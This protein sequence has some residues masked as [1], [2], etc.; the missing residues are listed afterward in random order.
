M[1]SSSCP[2]S[3]GMS[4]SSDTPACTSRTM[5]ALLPYGPI[6]PTLTIRTPPASWTVRSATPPAARRGGAP[7]LGAHR[8]FPRSLA[9]LVLLALGHG[10][11]I[12][13]RRVVGGER[14]PTF[15]LDVEVLADHAEH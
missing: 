6:G 11:H 7:G 5:Y 14:L 3:N 12:G 8:S 10:M 15:G 2:S 13:E 9:G 1:A 4:T